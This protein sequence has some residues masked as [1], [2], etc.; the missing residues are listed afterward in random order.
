MQ[1]VNSFT[2]NIASAVKE[3]DAATKE[4]SRNVQEAATGTTDVSGAIQETQHVGAQ[5]QDAAAATAGR[6]KSLKV[7]VDRSLADVAAA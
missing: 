6:S 2:T 3:Q 5:M 1:G 4:I 7:A